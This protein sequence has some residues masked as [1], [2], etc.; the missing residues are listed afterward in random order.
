MRKRKLGNTGIKVTEIGFGAWAIGGEGATPNYGE[1]NEKQAWEVINKYIESGGNYIDTARAY[2]N[3]EEYLGG[4]FS[5][6]GGREKIIISTKTTAVQTVKTIHQIRKDLDTSLSLMKTDYVDILFL[7]K[8]PEEDDVINQVIEELVSLINE[9]KI[10][11]IGTSIKGVDVS[12]K[13]VELSRKYMDTGKIDVIQIVYSILRQGHSEVIN[14]A[15]NRGI[16]IVART[17]LE[18]G[19]LT[20]KYAPDHK[21]EGNDQRTRYKDGNLQFVLKKVHEMKDFAVKEPYENLSQVAIHFALSHEGVSS[22]IVGAKNVKQME[23]NMKTA[24]LPPLKNDLVNELRKKY[25]DITERANY[26]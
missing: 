18:S 26:N 21:F 24:K 20:G 5:T 19:L 22:L 16:G 10:R 25:G 2:N 15:Y 23:M 6:Y 9:G 1:V 4:Y 3:C 13:T 11:A 7:H 8:P 14:E 17:A 12:Q